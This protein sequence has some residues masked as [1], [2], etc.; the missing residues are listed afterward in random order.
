[1]DDPNCSANFTRTIESSIVY[2]NVPV[3]RDEHVC[4]SP[5]EDGRLNEQPD[6]DDSSQ[7]LNEQF[8]DELASQKDANL[9]LFSKVECEIRDEEL[10]QQ[11]ERLWKTDFENTEVET[12]V[13]ASVEDKRAQEI[14]EG[15]LQRVDGHLQV[16]LPWRHDPP[17]LLNNKMLAERRA[18]LLK[19][20]LMKDKDLLEK[21]RT[22]MDDYIEKGHAEMVPEEELNTRNRPVWFLPHHPVTHP[23]KPDKV[24]VVYD[25]A[26]KFGQTSLNQQLLQGPDQTN[27]LVGVV[28][29]KTPL[30]W[31]LILKQCFVR[32]L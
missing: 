12:K 5:I 16:A 26:A 19:R 10:H 14:M 2:D 11:L 25:C 7:V 21:Y 17:Y 30:E 27:R 3:L 15:S 23:L 4:L 24:R 32:S 31:L 1:M 22:T 29:D 6:D 28:S 9:L 13:C 8:T 18:L 20:R